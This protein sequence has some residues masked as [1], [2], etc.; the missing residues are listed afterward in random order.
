[1][2][3][4]AT[5][6]VR[7]GAEKV[8][9]SEGVCERALLTLGGLMLAAASMGEGVGSACESLT[10]S[11]TRRAARA[12]KPDIV[13]NAEKMLTL[14]SM[15]PRVGRA[16]Q[17]I[18]LAAPWKAHRSRKLCPGRRDVSRQSSYLPGVAPPSVRIPELVFASPRSLP[19]VSKLVGRVVVLDIAFAASSGSKVSFEKVTLPLIEGLGP[20]LAAW[21]DH[22]DHER[23]SDYSDDSRFLLRTKAEHGACPEMVTPELVER[24]APVDTIVMH[25]DLDG[26]YS[27]AKW[28]L[29][30]KEPY[31]G[32]DYD[33][34]C[35]D[36]RTG[37]PGPI[38]IKIDRALRAHFRDQDLKRAVVLWLVGGMGKTVHLETI[39]EAEREFDASN[40]GT[41]ALAARFTARGRVAL[42]DASASPEPYDKTEL[43]LLGQKLAPI[44]AVVDSG[45]VTFAASF[46]SGWN[47]LE[48]LGLE[49][50]M[51]TRVSISEARLE[52]AIQS[53][54]DAPEPAR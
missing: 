49:G 4:P 21:V 50:G 33:A 24:C 19:K 25:L 14:S 16:G 11:T 36:T 39:N 7:E 38:A 5:V 31:E 46:D 51:P 34:R 47:F 29:G 43:L 54:N 17:K 42:V 2:R 28:I 15:L 26:L 37:E 10:G 32:A 23:H 44:A 35:I 30:G 40:R 3:N 9:I 13:R 27:A 45:S 18:T 48:I 1:M 52:E 12:D 22:H 8:S 41:D 20:R 6:L 53:L